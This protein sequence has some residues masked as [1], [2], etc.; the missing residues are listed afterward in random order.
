MDGDDVVVVWT[1]QGG[2]AVISPDG[3]GGYGS[4]LLQRTMSG[5]LGGTIEFDWS[6]SGAL[7]TLRINSSRLAV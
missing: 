3:E 6:P 1:E 2:P 4:K 7:I 5:H